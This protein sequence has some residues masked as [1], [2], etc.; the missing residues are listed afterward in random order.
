MVRQLHNS[1]KEPR[2]MPNNMAGVVSV[3]LPCPKCDKGTPYPLR[4]LRDKKE[5]A[6]RRCGGPINLMLDGNAA[7]IRQETEKFEKIKP[8]RRL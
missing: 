7:L 8:S 5:V 1:A 4:E 6:C 2:F 3:S